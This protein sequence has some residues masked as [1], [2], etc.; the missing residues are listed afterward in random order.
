MPGVNTDIFL[1]IINSVKTILVILSIFPKN[2]G[3]QYPPS[4]PNVSSNVTGISNG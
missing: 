4:I 3:L 2:T 1:L